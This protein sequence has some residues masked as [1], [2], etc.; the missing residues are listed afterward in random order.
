M[1]ASDLSNGVCF[2]EIAVYLIVTDEDLDFGE[3]IDRQSHG[4]PCYRYD[5]IAT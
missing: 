3:W 2:E 4:T 5:S 1:I